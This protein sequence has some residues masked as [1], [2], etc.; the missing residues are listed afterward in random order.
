[1]RKEQ[2]TAAFANFMKGKGLGSENLSLSSFPIVFLEFFRDVKFA[3][4]SDLDD[5]LLLF[6]YGTYDWGEG[7]FF[8]V[9]F[10]RQ[11]CRLISG[12]GDCE[13][14]QQHFTF[15]FDPTDFTE[16]AAFSVWSNACPD[17]SDFQSTI[18]NSLGYIATLDKV[19]SKI[20]TSVGHVC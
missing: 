5:D 3:E 10:T 11:Y 14:T 6:Q 17:L 12:L 13:I 9:D 4:Y 19:P 20:E 1:M 8:E 15:Y 2:F 18:T 16:V 7:R